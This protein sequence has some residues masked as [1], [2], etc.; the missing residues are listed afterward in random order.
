[1]RVH[2]NLEEFLR[3][4]SEVYPFQKRHS[5]GMRRFER[6]SRRKNRRK[7]LGLAVRGKGRSASPSIGRTNTEQGIQFFYHKEHA[8]KRLP[9]DKAIGYGPNCFRGNG[10]IRRS[11]E[12]GRL[13]FLEEI[14]RKKIKGFRR[15]IP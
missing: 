9:S 8:E 4:N 2:S 3:E 13:K 11:G 14:W 7:K 10:S 6:K 12:N 5:S 1:M 15:K